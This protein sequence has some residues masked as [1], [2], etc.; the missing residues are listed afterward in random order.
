MADAKNT[1]FSSGFF[2]ISQN[3]A[4]VWRFPSDCWNATQPSFLRFDSFSS[5]LFTILQKASPATDGLGKFI[6][7]FLFNRS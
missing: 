7:M 1:H 3:A 6:A 2:T 4:L 5:G